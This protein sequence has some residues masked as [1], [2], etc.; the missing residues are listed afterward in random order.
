MTNPNPLAAMLAKAKESKDESVQRP[1][2]GTPAAAEVVS[3]DVQ[4]SPDIQ[5]SVPTPAAP[6]QGRR[7][8]FG[9]AGIRKPVSNES[10]SKPADGDATPASGESSQPNRPKLAGLKLGSAS[11]TKQLPSGDASKVDGSVGL[12]LE[13]LSE[14]EDEGIAPVTPSGYADET[15]A[16]AP[17]RELPEGITKEE[18]NFIDTVDS[19]YNILHDPDLLGGVVRN[20]L[21]ELKS[22]PEY[23]KLVAPEDVRQWVRGMRESMGLARIKK[24]EAKAKRSG[25]AGAK[26]KLVDMDMLAELDSLANFEG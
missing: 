11:S 15:P 2:E 22:H 24:T 7:N 21:I 25:G 5:A 26:S 8:P 14:S 6:S 12:S 1:D 3:E 13:S 20:I 10:E 17:T 4:Q 9:G 23:M 19:I 18:L 16:T